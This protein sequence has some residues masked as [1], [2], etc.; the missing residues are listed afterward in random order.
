MVTPKDADLSVLSFYS[1]DSGA[2]D[3]KLLCLQETVSGCIV[4]YGI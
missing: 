3:D 2:I 1:V 4:G